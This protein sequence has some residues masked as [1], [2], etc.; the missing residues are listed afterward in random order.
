MAFVSLVLNDVKLQGFIGIEN[1]ENKLQ[2]LIEKVD[3]TIWI[4]DCVFLL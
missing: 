3:Q 4:D 2:G 1:T